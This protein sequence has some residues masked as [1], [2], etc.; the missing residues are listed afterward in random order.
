MRNYALGLLLLT[1]LV[2]YLTDVLSV[3]SGYVSFMLTLV[4]VVLV[5]FASSALLRNVQNLKMTRN[6]MY[7]GLIGVVFGLIFVFWINSNI[8]AFSDWFEANGLVMLLIIN[9]ICALTIFLVPKP[10][11]KK[12]VSEAG[13]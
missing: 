6:Y 12:A 9:V 1:N 8:S 2:I 3:S 11:K 13:A 7:S 4:M 10:K 5:A